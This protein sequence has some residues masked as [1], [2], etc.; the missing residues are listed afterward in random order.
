MLPR[1]WTLSS[2]DWIGLDW[3]GWV[4][5]PSLPWLWVVCLDYD[6]FMRLVLEYE[7]W[8]QGM[9]TSFAPSMPI[10]CP[11]SLLQTPSPETSAVGHGHLRSSHQT[12][13]LWV[14]AFLEEHN[15]FSS[16]CIVFRSVACTVVVTA[17]IDGS[18]DEVPA[19]S[20][21]LEEEPFVDINTN[22]IRIVQSKI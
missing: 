10:N 1:F 18:K 5:S 14:T 8:S 15:W 2:R 6:S 4:A 12:W 19:V 9:F 22:A 11:S 21:F 7:L 20:L 13:L 3:I 16:R 17:W